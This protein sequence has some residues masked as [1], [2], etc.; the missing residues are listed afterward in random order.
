MRIIDTINKN[1]KDLEP[2]HTKSQQSMPNPTNY[3]A[4]TV[5]DNVIEIYNLKINILYM[6]K[7]ITVHLRGQIPLTMSRN[8]F[9][10]NSL[11]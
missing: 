7:V 6:I 10:F 9:L 8:N 3:V 5:N 4:P 1:L 2:N 11:Y